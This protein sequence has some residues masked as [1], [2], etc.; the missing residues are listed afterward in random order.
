MYD[1]ITFLPLAVFWGGLTL[2]TIA[3][4]ARAIVFIYQ[5]LGKSFSLYDEYEDKDGNT[6]LIRRK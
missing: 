5:L 2:F 1:F 6:I 3:L 4:C